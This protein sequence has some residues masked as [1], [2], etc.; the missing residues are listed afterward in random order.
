M[1]SSL[2][3]IGLGIVVLLCIFLKNKHLFSKKPGKQEDSQEE[4]SASAKATATADEEETIA[5]A[6]VKSF[7]TL[8]QDLDAK[9]SAESKKKTEEDLL[10]AEKTRMEKID[11]EGKNALLEGAVLLKKK[12]FG[13]SNLDKAKDEAEI[14]EIRRKGQA[15][16][17]ALAAKAAEIDRKARVEELLLEAEKARTQR[18]IQL[19]GLTTEREKNL[20]VFDQYIEQGNG[21]KFSHAKFCVTLVLI[22]TIVVIACIALKG[23]GIF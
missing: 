1:F 21:K 14:A 11:Q 8:C 13:V 3:I 17:L 4:E 6:D 15:E 10:A 20:A 5:D 22:A 23:N 2:D 19:I 18:K 12:K 16:D 9:E 7:M